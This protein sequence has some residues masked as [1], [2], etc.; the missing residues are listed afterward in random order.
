M[1]NFSRIRWKNFL[2]TGDDFTEIVLNKF[3]TTLI[4]GRNGSGKS[5]L[6]DALMFSL[7]GEPFRNINLPQ[8]VNDT[9]ERELVVEIEF[10]S[11]KTNYKIR[12][13]LKPRL[14]E[15]YKNNVLIDQDSKA[16]DY[17]K[18]LEQNI[19]KMNKKSFKQIVVLGSAAFVPF[20]QLTA[21][22]RRNIIEDLLDIQIF[23]SMNLVL[24]QH[25]AEM[26]DE[27][28]SISN[29]IELQ[30][31][32]IAL[33]T[34][35]L[36]KLKSDN[37]NAIEDKK[38]SVKDNKIQRHYFEDDI[39]KLYGEIADLVTVIADKEQI[40]ERIRKIENTEDKLKNTKIKHEK[41]CQ[42]YLES[43]HCPTCKQE[44][45]ADF[46]N[47]TINTKTGLIGEIENALEKL[48]IDLDKSDARMQ[49]IN[50]TLRIIE[51]KKEH[52][53]KLQS[54]I[55]AIDSYIEKIDMEISELQVKS[56]DTKE[57]EK[58]L[59]S[60]QK[61]MVELMAQKDTLTSRKHYLDI[62][63]VMLKDSGIKTKIIRQYLPIMN[64]YVNKYLAL[65]DFFAN[66]NLDEN[67]KD[68]IHIRGSK[69]RTYFQLSEGQKLRIDLAL[70]FTWR[71]IA[72]L[73]NSANCN[74][75]IMDE[76]FERSMDATGLEDLLKLIHNLSKDVNIFILS[77][78]GDLLVDKFT[79]TIKFIEERG[80]S[81]MEQ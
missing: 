12:R 41:D 29:S 26:R 10:S 73:K 11:G 66:F 40:A 24:K 65:M 37:A 77:P 67:F 30:T 6:L 79:N 45:D 44:I 78:Q 22:D 52:I 39:T 69:E 46:K 4:M 27:Y 71:E 48:Q 31:E 9:N 32:K 56:G 14:F 57:Q 70:L 61:E 38:S 2:A 15:I 25:V 63:A 7:F 17:Q 59:K 49:E 68:I 16:R 35:Y 1:V 34:S 53:G 19:L 42:F 23:S 20:M 60:L 55:R 43:D 72:K 76:I 18:Y 5:T 80:F 21:A 50:E 8:L 47:D 51:A 33:V 64:K 28:V 81:V 54:S 62:I 13:G 74:L 3:P 36:K 75:L 58:K